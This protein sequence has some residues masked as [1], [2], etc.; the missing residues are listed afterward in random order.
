MTAAI[1]PPST[2]RKILT[3]AERVRLRYVPTTAASQARINLSAQMV[4]C[5]NDPDK[6][7]HLL[8]LISAGARSEA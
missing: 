6:T 8:A 7:A 4:L 3:S 1:L 2:S 5:R